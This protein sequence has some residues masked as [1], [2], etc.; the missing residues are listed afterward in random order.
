M[1]VGDF[2]VVWKYDG[3]KTL[4]S[5][6]LFDYCSVVFFKS[7]L[8]L[9]ILKHTIMLS[10]IIQIKNTMKSQGGPENSVVGRHLL[11]F[12]PDDTDTGLKKKKL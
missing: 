5:C 8:F 12:T 7:Y 10:Y 1:V 3:E 11:W 9:T 6:G 4:I 2:Y